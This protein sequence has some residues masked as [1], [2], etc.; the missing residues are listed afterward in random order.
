MWDF[1]FLFLFVFV[2]LIRI[3]EIGKA[4]QEFLGI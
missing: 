3:S 4:D 2:F 1:F